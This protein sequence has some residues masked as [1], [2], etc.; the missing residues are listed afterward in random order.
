VARWRTSAAL[1][2]LGL[3]AAGCGHV[4]SS[5]ATS[6]A[7]TSAAHPQLELLSQQPLIVRGSGFKPHEPVAL[8]AKGT[9][10]SGHADA[11][12]DANGSFTATFKRLT[13][14]D[15]F[16]VAALGSKGSRAEFNLSQIACAGT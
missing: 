14:C 4:A 6:P 1:A 16:T 11:T 15:S 5:P 13:R 7:T 8:A 9:L 2:V 12:A 10:A 3:L